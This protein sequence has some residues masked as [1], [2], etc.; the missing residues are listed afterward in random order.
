MEETIRALQAGTSHPD[1]CDSDWNLFPGMLLPPKI[2][3]S[4]FKRYDG[5][6]D[7]RHHLRHYHS[8]MHS[9]WDYEEFV[10]HTFQD[11]LTGSALDWFM[12]LKAGD[13]PTW[14]DLSQ[15][16]LDQHMRIPCIMC[17]PIKRRKLISQPRQLLSSRN[18]RNSTLLFKFNKLDPRLRDLLSRLNVFQLLELNKTVLLNRVHASNTPLYQLPPLTYSGNFL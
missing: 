9:Y 6:K 16:F 11:S 15:K 12:T 3:I 14:T 7:P 2:K 10:I 4:D 18:L 8:K 5:T 17:N 13:F 1:F